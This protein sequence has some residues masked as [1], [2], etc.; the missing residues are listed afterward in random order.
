[1]STT[2]TNIPSAPSGSKLDCPATLVDELTPVDVPFVMLPVLVFDDE[3]F[4]PALCASTRL[5]EKLVGD[6]EVTCAAGR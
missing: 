5:K 3:A 6:V 4:S 2:G 1:M